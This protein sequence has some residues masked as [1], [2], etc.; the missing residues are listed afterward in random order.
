MRVGIALAS[1]RAMKFALGYYAL[2]IATVVSCTESEDEEGGAVA[3]A[4]CATGLR[5]ASG[6]AESPRMHP[7]ADCIG[8]HASGEGPQFVVAGTVQAAIDDPT[9]CYG[10]P[11]ATVTIT[12]ATGKSVMTT[13]NEAGNFYLAAREML[14]MPI[15]AVVELDGRLRSMTAQQM[16]GACA[17]CHTATG[18]NG[19]PG[20]ILAP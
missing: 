16:T 12:D 4:R 19:A 14:V 15:A 17:S 6:D 2:V 5:W 10:V 3:D 9:D 8:C 1:D 20:R 13:S 18:A 7:G 11:G